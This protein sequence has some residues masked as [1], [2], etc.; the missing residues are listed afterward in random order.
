MLKR[1]EWLKRILSPKEASIK[2]IH[3]EQI[4]RNI[5]EKLKEIHRG[6]KNPKVALP[7]KGQIDRAQG[8]GGK[9]CSVRVEGE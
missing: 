8:P 1:L 7:R 4:R 6:K 5:D 9:V 3:E 2:F